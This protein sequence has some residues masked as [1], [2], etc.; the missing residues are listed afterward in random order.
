MPSSRK[1]KLES[2][3]QREIATCIQQELKDPRLGFI[4]VVRVEMSEDLQ[5][6]KA[7]YTVLGDMKKRK[8]AEQALAHARGFVQGRY[9]DV[10]KT[11][12]LPTLSFHYDDAEFRRQTMTDLIRAARATDTDAGASPEPAAPTPKADAV[13]RKPR[14]GLRGP[15]SR[16]SA[17]GPLP[18]EPEIEPGSA[19][20]RD[21]S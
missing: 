5:Q 21:P 2:V 15:A 6:V 17:R 13:T 4:T 9:A 20:D 3:L 7:Y 12:R 14:P 19:L 18:G 10:V 8:L 11:R 16:G 1:A